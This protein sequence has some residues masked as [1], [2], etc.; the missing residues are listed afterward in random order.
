MQKMGTSPSLFI[1]LYLYSISIYFKVWIFFLLEIKDKTFY[2]LMFLFFFFYYLQFCTDYPW[3][4]HIQLFPEQFCAKAEG[5]GT[6]WNLVLDRCAVAKQEATNK[7]QHRKSWLAI[8]EGRNPQSTKP[9]QSPSLEIS[10]MWLWTAGSKAVQ[11]HFESRDW[12]R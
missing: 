4:S 5:M 11:S 2:L 3:S 9:M 7:L 12:I 10:C 8:M 6:K 1:I